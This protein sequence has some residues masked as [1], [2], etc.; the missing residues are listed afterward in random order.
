MNNIMQDIVSRTNNEVYIGVVGSV[1]SGKSTFIRKFMELK[2]IPNVDDEY[3]NKIIDEL[4]QSSAGKNIMTVE[5]KFVPSNPAVV[6]IDSDINFTIRAVDC[7]GYIMKNAKGYLN[8][9][10]SMKLVK[11]PWFTDE[12]PFMEAATIGTKKVME[13]HSHLGI[14]MTSDGSFGEFQRYEY[15]EIEETIIT[16]MKELNKPF[17]I[18]LNT[19]MPNNDDTANLVLTLE[20]KYDVSVLAVDVNNLTETDIDNILKAALN[21]FDITKLNINAPNWLTYL[22]DDNEYKST[23]NELLKEVTGEY[24]KF[25]QVLKIQESFKQCTLFED[26]IVSSI[27]SGTGEVNMELKCPDALYNDILNGIVGEA[28]N[29]KGEFIKFLEDCVEAK[30]EYGKYKSAIES[31]NSTGY[32]IATPILSDLTLD[33][34]TIVKQGSRYGI[35]LRAVAPSIHM[36]KVDVE[37]IFEPIIGTEEQSNKLLEKI[38]EDYDNN[39]SSIWTKEIFGRK[40]SEVVNDGIKAKLY[41]VPDNIQVKMKECLEKIVNKGKGGLLAIVL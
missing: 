14:V 33:E 15:E 27:N 39:H 21:E 29:D 1:R 18:V 41:L 11:T 7:V 13:N 25:K 12:I 37:S 6:N 35:K 3:K 24:R 36:I 31:V 8:D 34:P 2:V 32:G 23:F 5:P 17:V 19:S 22:H 10:G 20:Q 28:M 40:L 9:D 26:V 38:M 30:Q 4:P 16:E